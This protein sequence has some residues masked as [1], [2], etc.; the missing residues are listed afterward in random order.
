MLKIA[1]QPKIPWLQTEGRIGKALVKAAD[2][3]EDPVFKVRVVG[4]WLVNRALTKRVSISGVK[5][6]HVT[7]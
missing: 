2:K 7:I 5:D 6:K 1:L 3:V 4:A